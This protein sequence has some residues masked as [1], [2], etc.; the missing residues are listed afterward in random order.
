M[1][2]HLQIARTAKC[3]TVLGPGKRAVLWLQGCLR[4]CPGCISPDTWSQ[5]GGEIYTISELTDFIIGI[6]DIEGITFSGGE[7]MLQ[8]EGIISLLDEIQHTNLSTMLYTGYTFEDLIE[9]GTPAQQELI[10]RLD[11]LVDGTY[12]QQR[13]TS[14]YWRGSDNQRVLFLS[15]RYRESWCERVK[16]NNDAP[17]EFEID[18]DTVHWMGIPPKGFQSAFDEKLRT[19]GIDVI[20]QQSVQP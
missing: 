7:P 14:L 12:M 15:E 10:A 1:I 20:I 9:T 8:A 17:L 4:R 16:Q 18:H 6:T 2:N 3:C 13:H 5:E 11:I 19:I